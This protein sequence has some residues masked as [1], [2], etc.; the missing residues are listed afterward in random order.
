MSEMDEFD[1]PPPVP[2]ELL[3]AERLRALDREQRMLLDED[4]PSDH[5]IRALVRLAAEV[6]NGEDA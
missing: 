3:Q 2:A 1:G 6:R 4:D 5:S